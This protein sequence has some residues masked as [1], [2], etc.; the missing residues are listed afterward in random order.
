MRILAMSWRIVEV[1]K[2]LEVE[3]EEDKSAAVSKW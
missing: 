3:V 1:P 2:V